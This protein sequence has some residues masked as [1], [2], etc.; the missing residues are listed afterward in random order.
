MEV[1]AIMLNIE[2]L[3]NRNIVKINEKLEMKY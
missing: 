2:N 3:T 1:Y